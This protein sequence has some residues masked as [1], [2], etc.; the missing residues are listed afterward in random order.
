MAEFDLADRFDVILCLFSSMGYLR[1]LGRVEQALRC[2][3][4][5]LKPGGVVL[6]EPWFGPDTWS[7]GGVYV[8]TSESGETTVVRMSHSTTRGRLSELEFHYL[9]G[10][11][12]GVE[13]RV[14]RHTLGLFTTEEIADRF[15]RAGFSQVA[16]H[17][18]GLTGRGLFTA[19]AGPPTRDEGNN[20]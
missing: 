11:R 12:A 7:P 16:Y 17:P 13:H 8:H 3:H 2:F 5:H 9:I 19:R 1:E 18:E 15:R 4:R 6:L 10:T 20:P 14:E